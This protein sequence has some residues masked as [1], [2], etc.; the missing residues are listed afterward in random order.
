[1]DLKP[2]SLFICIFESFFDM[3]KDGKGITKY[4]LLKTEKR[5]FYI[6]TKKQR[7]DLIFKRNDNRDPIYN[8]VDTHI[9]PTS[10]SWTHPIRTGLISDFLPGDK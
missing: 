4:F 10:R 7:N 5:S 9:L 8:R 3:K 2:N 1:M 6:R